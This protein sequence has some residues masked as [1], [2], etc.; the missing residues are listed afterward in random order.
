MIHTIKNFYTPKEC[1]QIM[2]KVHDLLHDNSLNVS[3][4]NLIN[5]RFEFSDVIK[6]NDG[7]TTH[8]LQRFRAV[9]YD[10]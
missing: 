4:F 5:L 10:S 9:I 8:G 2:D 1:K 3:G 7:R 6:E